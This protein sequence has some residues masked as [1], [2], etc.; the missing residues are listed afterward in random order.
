VRKATKSGNSCVIVAVVLAV[1]ALVGSLG[2][3][4][5]GIVVYVMRSSKPSP[6][7]RV[8][9]NPE[10]RLEEV[11]AAFKEQKPL[12]VEEIA[13]GLKPMFEGLGGALR[14]ADAK[15]I[16]AY[17]DVDRMGDE[18][19]A[20]GTL[21]LRTTK[22]KQDFK[23][24]L[25]LGI[26]SSLAKAAL[27]MHWTES[28][29]RNVKKLNDQE[30]VV[31]VRHKH[32]NGALLKMRWWVTR[33]SGTWKVYDFED[34][35]MGMRMSTTAGSFAGQAIGRLAEI[36]RA[37]STLSEALQTVVL[38]QDPDGA[39]KK[40]QQV[41]RVKLPKLLEVLRS[42]VRGLI[43]FQQGRYQEALDAFEEAGRFQA[44]MP[45]LDFWKGTTLNRLGK[46]D[47]ALKHLQAYSDLLGEDAE[48]CREL[49]LAL[50][51]LKRFP[52]AAR[53]YRKSLDLDP[54]DGEAFL[55]FLRSLGGS[56]NKDD[57][58]ARF[59]KLDDLRDNFDVCAEDCEEREFPELLE[60]LVLAMRRV[61]PDYV[62]V[63]YYLSLVK[64]RTGRANE[65]VPLFKSAL[66]KQP[67]AQIRQ[68]Y[69]DR[70]LRA[71]ASAGKLADAYAAVPDTR[72]AFR[73]LAAEAVKRYRV[74]ELKELVAR[75]EKTHR[76]DPL[77]PWYQAEVYVQEGRYA[78]ADKTFASALA[79]P[80]DEETLKQ[81][82]PSRVL[83]RYHTG[84]GLSAY[85]DIGPRPDTFLQLA[86]L[87]L[88]HEEYA[89]LQDLLDAHAK[90]DPKSAELLRFRYRLKIRQNEVPDAI[91]LFKASLAKTEPD[92]ERTE[93]VSEF[94]REMA[95]A[96]K[97]LE[98]YRAAPDAEQA[99][100]VLA[101]SAV[102]E[103]RREDLRR[104]VEVHRAGHAADPMLAYYQGEIHVQDKDWDKAA[105]VLGAGLKQAPEKL[106]GWYRWKYV[107]AMYKAGRGL[108][109][110]GAAEPRGET[111][112]QLANLLAAD[113]KA[114]EMEA[115]IKA[116][117]PHAGDDPGLDARAA[118]A[119]VWLKQP[120]EA[121]ALVKKAYQ[122]QKD[123]NLR[124]GYVNRFVL[125]MD[126]AGQMLE[127]YR[128]APDKLSAFG[129]LA[130]RL[131]SSKKEKELA[132]LLDGHAK[133]HAGDP[134]CRFY[135]GE[136]HLLRGDVKQAEEAF[137]AAQAKGL[138]PWRFR[139]GLFRARV[140]AGKAAETYHEIEP[141]PT[142]FQSLAYLCIENKDAKQ[143]QALIDAHRKA[144]PDDSNLPV[145]DM[146]VR[147][148]KGDHE[149]V[150][151]LLSEHD[152]DFFCL[153][154]HRWKGDDYRVRSLVKLKRTKDAIAAAEA[155]AKRKGN[156]VLLVLAHAA[157]GDVKQ[158]I[159]ALEKRKPESYL[160]RSC[161][162]DT[163]L[164]P[165]LRTEPFRE[166]RE[167]FPVPKE[168][169]P[170]VEP[171]DD[172][173]P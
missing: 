117:R 137:Q 15:R 123:E 88:D 43:R 154:R 54:K 164:G 82:R 146:E 58:G 77:L 2:A 13:P 96:G 153:P 109:A 134:L 29:I 145:W 166:F 86:N 37:T 100:Q 95:S 92:K 8:E 157:A 110:Y 39:E 106:R 143:L 3:A 111:F 126:E 56:D 97:S 113:K 99:F 11:R 12:A 21:P 120:A 125:D 170:Q 1:V 28:D 72:A 24:G 60:P 151:Q 22:E 136:W 122:A 167:K 90:N 132:A 67:D 31:I 168:E 16:E 160:I 131:V 156:R 93:R 30:A 173:E 64:A 147:W 169:P 135:R 94:L 42:L 36:R 45:V 114:T 150:L 46:W 41:A 66:A 83:A 91:A 49:G 139:D 27:L 62:S 73:F 80:P 63:D 130:P 163:D 149:G 112:N 161:Y 65:A 81:F 70:F 116:H 108:E 104:L 34:L 38:Q 121:A 55:G 159:A 118:R 25:R 138:P 18:I 158:T 40:L 87:C 155:V 59:V 47:R 48:V 128:L 17:F 76:D 105:K 152:E 26:G 172:D 5:L 107:H 98:G 32:P 44:D 129:A 9:E 33:R 84:R 53:S 50:R 6:P 171:D 140:K 61:D 57:I 68:T 7:A 79:K 141:G 74:Q 89:Q 115:L 101:Q 75:H 148:L 133:E 144:R 102:N 124:K 85:R 10:E 51:G 103:S 119:K 69:V 52:E 14:A 20:L 142:T 19:I 165:I 71:M 127:G 35:D 162:Q 78:L 4:G 23:Q